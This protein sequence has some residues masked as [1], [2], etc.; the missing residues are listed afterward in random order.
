[1]C[2]QLRC[3]LKLKFNSGKLYIKDWHSPFI[4]SP[5][6]AG[7]HTHT[8]FME[9]DCLTKSK[10]GICCEPLQN[11][12][13]ESCTHASTRAFKYAQRVSYRI[14]GPSWHTSTSTEHSPCFGTMKTIYRITHKL[15]S[16]HAYTHTFGSNSIE[17]QMLLNE[18]LC[19][20]WFIMWLL[21]I[22]FSTFITSYSWLWI[23]TAQ[24]RHQ[25][26]ALNGI[27]PWMCTNT[28]IHQR[29]QQRFP[30]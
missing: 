18:L 19:W 21:K 26:H 12:R 24:R 27:Q 6:D 1:M 22:T 29:A 7:K 4:S 28:Y 16:T 9:A 14:L 13:R 3:W 17:Q 23:F 8:H 10:S 2:E 30:C 25:I 5:F 11:N 20:A 15:S